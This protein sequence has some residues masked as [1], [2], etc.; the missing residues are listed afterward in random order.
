MQRS[1]ASVLVNS[2]ITSLFLLFAF[3][4]VGF[5]LYR[6]NAQATAPLIADYNLAV[7]PNVLV[8]CYRAGCGCEAHYSIWTNK[9]IERKMPVLIISNDPQANAPEFTALFKNKPVIVRTNVGLAIFN[10]FSPTKTTTLSLVQ[11]GHIIKQASG[12][13][14]FETIISI[15]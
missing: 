8:V 14:A 9:A 10:Q 6:A 4:G 11:Y 13:K 15:Q 5:Q 7:K 1:Y 2:P 12:A 3:V